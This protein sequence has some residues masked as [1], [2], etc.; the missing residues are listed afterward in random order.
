MVAATPATGVLVVD[1]PAGITSHDVVAQARKR[2]G[3]RGVGHAGTLDPMATGVLLLLFGEATKLSAYLTG[4]DKSYDALVRFGRSTDTLDADGSAVAERALEAGEISGDTLARALAAERVRSLQMPPA[5]SALKI[6]GRPAHRR[7][8]SGEVVELA[9][10]KVRVRALDVVGHGADWV[11][12]CL[13]VS[14][15]YY[16]RALARDLGDLLGVPAHLAELRR[17][18]SGAFTLADAVTW[19]PSDLPPL[20]AAGAAAARCLPVAE[21]TELGVARARQGKVLQSEHFA[22]A[23]GDESDAPNAWL[24]AGGRLVAIGHRQ[25]DRYVVARGFRDA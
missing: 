1:K 3:Q 11:R 10:R 21:L 18:A 13:T 23:S 2:Y 14:K 25:G 12:L 17:T 4:D 6:A 19:P 16:V 20:L 15:G 9:P 24:D 22:K 7:A 5:V 8:R